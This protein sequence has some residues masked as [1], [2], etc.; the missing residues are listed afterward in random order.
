MS[1]LHIISCHTTGFPSILFAFIYQ[2]A[3]CARRNL[4]FNSCASQGF[5]SWGLGLLHALG[6]SV[7]IQYIYVRM[8]TI[9]SKFFLCMCF[10]TVDEINKAF[11]RKS[12]LLSRMPNRNFN[13]GE[14]GIYIIAQWKMVLS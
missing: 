8:L 10:T 9:F 11:T 13:L 1:S 12:D 4:Q 5:K 2:Q 14:F 7:G 3:I 6:Y